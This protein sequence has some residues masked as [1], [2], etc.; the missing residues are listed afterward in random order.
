MKKDQC[1]KAKLLLDDIDSLN[2]ILDYCMGKKKKSHFDL[3]SEIRLREHNVASK[4]LNYC[5]ENPRFKEALKAAFTEEINALQ[6][7]FDNL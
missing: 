2:Y 4:L 5:K 3:Y 7:E 6:E 1:I